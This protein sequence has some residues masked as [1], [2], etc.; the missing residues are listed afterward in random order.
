MQEGCVMVNKILSLLLITFI[1]SGCLGMENGENE[2]PNDELDVTT[3]YKGLITIGNTEDEM[4]VNEA[5]YE[6]I[7]LNEYAKH[8]SPLVA[9][10]NGTATIHIENNPQVTVYLWEDEVPVESNSFSLPY[11]T[12]RYTYNIEAKWPN[13]EASFIAV[14]EVPYEFK[15]VKRDEETDDPNAWIPSPNGEK[16]VMIEGL[17]EFEATGTI[18]LK[19]LSRESV[20]NIDFN[21]GNQWTAKKID[22]YDDHSVFITIGLVHGTVTRGGD[23]YHLDLNTLELTPIIELPIKEEVVDFSIEDHQ[24]TYEVHIYED[25]QM[26]EGYMETRILELSTIKEKIKDFQG[27]SEMAD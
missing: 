9:R 23:L 27:R 26:S 11:E 21:H 22:W 13:D 12:G 1:L 5:R 8:L 25:D 4:I 16:Q 20:T 19:E 6:G 7:P 24:L 14:I 17:G 3:I 2:D 15:R 10:P 18:V